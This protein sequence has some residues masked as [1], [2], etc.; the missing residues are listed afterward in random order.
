MKTKRISFLLRTAFVLFFA[1]SAFSGALADESYYI[2]GGT[3]SV[4]ATE[5]TG[6]E[7]IT[8]G[9]ILLTSGWYIVKSSNITY[10]MI[11]KCE[12]GD[13]NLILADGAHLT[14]NNSYEC[15]Y[16]QDGSLNIYRQSGGT[17]I[18]TVASTGN[19]GIYA[20]VNVN[21]YGGN[22]HATGGSS[23]GSGIYAGSS[24]TIAGGT[25]NTTGNKGI[26]SNGSVTITGGI[27][28]AY[29]TSYVGINANS[30]STTAG[31]VTGLVRDNGNKKIT[32][33]GRTFIKDGNWNTLC[34]PF[35]ATTAQLGSGVTVKELD[36]TNTSLDDSGKLTLTFTNAYSIE[37]CKPYIVKWPSGTNV[38]NPY[39]TGDSG[40]PSISDAPLQ[41]ITSS[42]EKVK[43]VGQFSPFA[44]TAE[45]IDA[46]LYIASGNKIGYSASARELKYCGAHFWVKPDE[47]GGSARTI[48]VDFGDGETISISGVTSLTSESND[49]DGTYYDLQGRRVAHPV[50]K[51]LYIVSGHKVLVK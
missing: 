19:H 41:E 45:N 50:Q 27:V 10:T 37:A 13:I 33:Y 28:S 11:L 4:A 31:T 3:K 47:S 16:V 29:G 12:S 18:L 44:I 6:N 20:K 2:D 9:K 34:L 25:V 26:D 30:F 23:D 43:F 21:I 17:G 40:A 8:D 1:V 5:L 38:A 32:L 48:D 36:A 46:I 51:G 24:V 42:D 15:L 14:I 35:N 49:T 39:F 22:I 7:T